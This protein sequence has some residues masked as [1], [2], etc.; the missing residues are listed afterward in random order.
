MKK[1][2]PA[3]PGHLSHGAVHLVQPVE[4]ERHHRMSSGSRRAKALR[5]FDATPIAL[6]WKAPHGK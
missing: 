4:A 2:G 6:N 5:K 1:N 3:K